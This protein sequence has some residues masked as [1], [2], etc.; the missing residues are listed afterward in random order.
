MQLSPFFLQT[1]CAVVLINSCAI[2]IIHTLVIFILVNNNCQTP[3]RLF[4]LQQLCADAIL[5]NDVDWIDKDLPEP[6]V[7]IG[8]QRVHID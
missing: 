8:F 4:N 3:G 6:V 7:N 1:C 5:S 2:L